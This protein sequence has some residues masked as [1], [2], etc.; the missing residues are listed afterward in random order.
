LPFGYFPFSNKYSSG[1]LMPTYGEDNR[2]GFYLR[3]GGYYFAFSD[4]FDSSHS[5]CRKDRHDSVRAKR[6]SR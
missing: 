1:I 6:W 3:N 5:S 4:S 2:Y